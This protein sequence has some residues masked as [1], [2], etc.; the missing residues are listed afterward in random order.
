[1]DGRTILLQTIEVVKV[2]MTTDIP[3]SEFD[4]PGVK[5][6]FV[7]NLATLLGIDPTRIRVA[8]VA[9]RR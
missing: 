4:K 1:M 6:G 9:V 5:D 7:N 2:S 8:A 3:V